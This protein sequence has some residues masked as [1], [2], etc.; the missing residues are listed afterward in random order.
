LAFVVA[1]IVK[2]VGRRLSCSVSLLGLLVWLCQG[3]QL[4]HC[5]G[6]SVAVG[7]GGMIS[8][9]VQS[10]KMALLKGLRANKKM[11]RTGGE[12]FFLLHVPPSRPPLIFGVPEA[13]GRA[14]GMASY[15]ALSAFGL[16]RCAPQEPNA[17]A[18]G[19]TS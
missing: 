6:T 1:A 11:Q 8:R 14:S 12:R 9:A 17:R 10:P 19:S 3:L 4:F 2:Q 7:F 5:S 13:R 18:A 16:R 15:A